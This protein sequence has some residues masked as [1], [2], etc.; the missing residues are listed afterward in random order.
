MN[1]T[2]ILRSLDHADAEALVWNVTF[3]N[4]F[5][6]I[7]Q[8]PDA[9]NVAWFINTLVKSEVVTDKAFTVD[10]YFGQSNPS[11]MGHGELCLSA[12]VKRTKAG[13]E[14]KYTSCDPQG[15]VAESH[16]Y[17]PNPSP[18]MFEEEHGFA[19]FLVGNSSDILMVGEEGA[20]RGIV[21]KQHDYRP[22]NTEVLMRSGVQA[23]TVMVPATEVSPKSLHRDQAIF[24]HA[25]SSKSKLVFREV[26]E[27][28]RTA[29]NDIEV[30]DR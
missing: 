13:V 24:L 23:K 4:E 28:S 27:Y 10:L 29:F 14:Y 5:R 26:K 6:T 17:V 7:G 1:Y 12:D 15:E 30:Q 20:P 9:S 22:S 25:L 16:G 8:S 19:V 11:V 18:Y 3:H 21:A 2:M